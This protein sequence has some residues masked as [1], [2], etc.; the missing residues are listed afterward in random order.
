MYACLIWGTATYT[1]IKNEQTFSNAIVYTQQTA[2]QGTSFKIT[3]KE[4]LLKVANKL[5]S[6]LSLSDGATYLK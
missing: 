2:S 4:Y 3:L 1:L 5:F 6:Y